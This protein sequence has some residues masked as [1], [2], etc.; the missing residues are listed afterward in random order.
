MVLV[1]QEQKKVASIL[2]ACSLPARIASHE[3]PAHASEYL[4]WEVEIHHHNQ[5]NLILSQPENHWFWSII[6]VLGACQVYGKVVL[7]RSSKSTKYELQGSRGDP[8]YEKFRFDSFWKFLTLPDG[9]FILNACAQPAFSDGIS[10]EEQLAVLTI[11][12]KKNFMLCE[13]RFFGHP[14][15]VLPGRLFGTQMEKN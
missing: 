11:G 3:N 1:P 5:W 12:L 6:E 8:L 4:Q 10:N 15:F 14:N 13:P 9:F 7:E 2:E